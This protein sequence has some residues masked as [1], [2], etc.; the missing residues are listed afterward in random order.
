MHAQRNTNRKTTTLEVS[1]KFINL[2]I[3]TFILILVGAGGC[4]SPNPVAVAF[5]GMISISIIDTMR[6]IVG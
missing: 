2:S 3:T 5:I 1:A 6:V 4:I